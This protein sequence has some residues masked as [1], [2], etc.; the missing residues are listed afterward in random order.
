MFHSVCSR[1]VHGFAFDFHF[2]TSFVYIEVEYPLL[3]A[4]NGV[5]KKP[6]K[7][8]LVILA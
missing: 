1:E 8:V 4:Q 3:L 6:L 7:H 5:N 2:P